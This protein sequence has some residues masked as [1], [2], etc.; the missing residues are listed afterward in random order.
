MTAEPSLASPVRGP[1]IL[2]RRARPSCMIPWGAASGA[3]LPSVA[4]NG[5]F[6][7]ATGCRR[8]LDLGCRGRAGSSSSPRLL[9]R[10]LIA[11]AMGTQ[12]PTEAC[13]RADHAISDVVGGSSRHSQP[14]WRE[15]GSAL[16]LEACECAG[17][18]GCEPGSEPPED[19]ADPS[20]VGYDGE[21]EP[22]HGAR[23]SDLAVASI[24]LRRSSE[25]RRRAGRERFALP[26]SSWAPVARANPQEALVHTRNLGFVAATF[27]NAVVAA[28]EELARALL[29]LP[30]SRHAEVATTCCRSDR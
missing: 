18:L 1:R 8:R 29:H 10:G 13:L 16:L 30:I 22:V 4:A 15:A 27:V 6:A 14:S 5:R 3:V 12:G 2:A 7:A 20:M 24:R 28:R 25:L 11:L 21:G 17:E 23:P 26:S 9:R 19:S